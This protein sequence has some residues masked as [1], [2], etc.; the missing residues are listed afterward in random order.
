MTYKASWLFVL[1]SLTGCK[2]G[3]D[4][5][6]PVFP[7]PGHWQIERQEVDLKSVDQEDLKT[8][9]K[10]FGDP[11]LNSLMAQA[12]ESNLDLQIALTRVDQARAERRGSRAE[13]FPSVNADAGA[14]RTQNPLP[15]L[16]PGIRFNQFQ[17]G[18]DA[19][20]EI[21]LFGRLQRRLE[22]A[23]A[24]LDAA[25]EQHRQAM[26]M[27]TSELARSY[28]EYRSLQNQL[29]ITRSNQEAQRHTLELTELLFKEGVGTR[30]DVVRAR[31]LT[32][33]TAAQ[34]PAL[35]GQ[36]TATLRQLEVLL[37]QQPGTLAE[38]LY[39][40]GNVPSAPGQAILSTP[41]DTIRHRPDVRSAERHLAA[42]T[43]IQGAAIAELFPKISLSAFLGLRNT[44][45][46][47][48]F[49]SAAFSYGTAANLLQPLIN[50][51]RIRAGIDLAKAKQKEAYLTYEKVVLEA[52]Q[53]TETVMTSYLKEE[54]RRQALAR[55][56]AD[57]QESV[58]LSQ[59]RYTEGAIS[60]LDVLDSQRILY[61]SEID[62]ARSEAKASTNL[63]AVYKALGG[64]ANVIPPQIPKGK[65]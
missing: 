8:W 55:A 59:L 64:G 39:Q 45:I 29:R 40:P 34:I 52:L 48:L 33:S 65:S 15:G 46:E 41:A 16:V 30:H 22:A 10:S 21:D 1:M 17:L 56:V 3:P 62:L 63:I 12:L 28:I 18:F 5:R 32:E 37:G 20:W 11:L 43:A 47:T 6:E 36:V 19:L 54:V 49:K 31:A 51:G 13:L 25:V 44:D 60:F 61:V 58:R 7:L 35:E 27:L 38:S 23:S 50:F 9:W 24:D 2:A 42:A 53:E 57:L 4:Y 26:V 14:L